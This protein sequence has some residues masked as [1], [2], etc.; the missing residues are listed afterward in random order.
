MLAPK[1]TRYSLFTVL[2]D[3]SVSGEV[4]DMAREVMLGETGRSTA[5]P[6]LSVTIEFE[7]YGRVWTSG[8]CEMF[9]GSPS[10]LPARQKS[11]LLYIIRDTMGLM[12]SRQLEKQLN[13]ACAK[14]DR[15]GSS[16]ISR[17]LGD[18]V[19]LPYH[20]AIQLTMDSS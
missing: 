15:V 1:W 7:R 5:S 4:E 3:R 18:T 13:E 17:F 14:A 8:G 19:S 6:N 10:H 2:H 12:Q 16:Q 11:L 20:T 9:S